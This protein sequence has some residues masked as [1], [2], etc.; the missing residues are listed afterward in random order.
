MSIEKGITCSYTPGIY[1][2]GYIAFVFPFVHSY[3]R[4]FVTFRRVGIGLSERSLP[5]GLLVFLGL[6]IVYGILRR[7]THASQ[8]C[9]FQRNVATRT[10]VLTLIFICRSLQIIASTLAYSRPTNSPTNVSLRELPEIGILEEIM[11]KHRGFLTRMCGS[12]VRN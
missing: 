9:Q 7:L 11:C 8:N 2:E 10:Q 5:L 12:W 3:V 1:A 6:I 4:S